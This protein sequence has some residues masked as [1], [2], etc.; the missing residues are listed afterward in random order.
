MMRAVTV[1]PDQGHLLA[2][3]LVFVGAATDARFRAFDLKT[4][5]TRTIR[6]QLEGR[7]CCQYDVKPATILRKR[8]V[9]GVESS[10]IRPEWLHYLSKILPRL[11]F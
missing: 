3:G 4:G 10:K 6:K 9:T 5:K 11:S 8:S 7:W 1:R 2:G